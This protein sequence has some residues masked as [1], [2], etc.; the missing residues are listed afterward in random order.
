MTQLRSASDVKA[1][2]RS[3]AA[4]SRLEQP[5]SPP[6]P[7]SRLLSLSPAAP[8]SSLDSTW[9]FH[10][11]A[12]GKCLVQKHDAE[13]KKGFTSATFHPDGLILATGTRGSATLASFA[14]GGNR[15]IYV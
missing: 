15:Q 4:L 1:N 14:R 12:A 3:T 2:R 8:P 7:S 11:I 6:L 10:D 9:A 13:I 5:L